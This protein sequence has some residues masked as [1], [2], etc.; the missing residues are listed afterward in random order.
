VLAATPNPSTSTTIGSAGEAA[1]VL[2]EVLLACHPFVRERLALARRLWRNPPELV[3]FASGEG[4]RAFAHLDRLRR[5]RNLVVHTAP[6]TV[7]GDAQLAQIGIDL[8]D[9]TF[10]VAPLWIPPEAPWRAL[11]EALLHKRA[12]WDK[13]GAGKRPAAHKILHP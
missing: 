6:V 8:L 3:A 4:R 10:E 13:L 1:A 9:A 11:R 5:A 2:D 7:V 12:L